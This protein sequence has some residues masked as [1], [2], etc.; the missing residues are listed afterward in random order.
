MRYILLAAGWMLFI[1]GILL[2]SYTFWPVMLFEML[3][4]LSMPDHDF[5][6][7]EEKSAYYDQRTFIL[8]GYGLMIFVGAK[9]IEI[10]HKRRPPVKIKPEME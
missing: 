4:N 3:G 5:V 9:C 1:V 6:S 8:I 2:A 7:W 10:S